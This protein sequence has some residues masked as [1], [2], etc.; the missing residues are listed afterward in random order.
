MTVIEA[1]IEQAKSVSHKGHLA[2]YIPALANTPKDLFAVYIIDEHGELFCSGDYN[3]SFTLQ[4]IS[5]VMSFIVA[6][7]KIGLDQVLEKVDVEPTGDPFNSIVRLEVTEKGKPFNPM[8]NAGAI[9]IASLL[10][11]DSVKRRVQ[12]VT[13]FLSHVTGQEHKVNEEVYQSEL[14]T[15]YRNRAIANYLKANDYLVGRVEEA[16]ETYL[17]LCSIEFTTKDLAKFGLFLA[18]N[19]QSINTNKRC[20]SKKTAQFT[21]ALMMTCG[22]Y[23][24][25]GKYAA[26]VGF[27]M[28]TGVSGGVLCTIRDGQIEQLKGSIGIG[29]FSP[30]IDEVGNSVAG[31]HFLQS[32]SETYDLSVF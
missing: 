28:K 32:L 21:K 20:I 12:S 27:P 10:P 22:L 6:A 9:T 31:M 17:Q 8:I 15:A 26:T 30:A 24:A 2:T 16:L 18:S 5:K 7:E 14:E 11:G 23:N 4:S 29:V 13:D 25:S 3:Y 1:L 19:G